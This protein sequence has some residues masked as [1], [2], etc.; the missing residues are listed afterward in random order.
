MRT[1][2]LLRTVLTELIFP[3]SQIR[4]SSTNVAQLYGDH[5][6]L[7]IGS[8]VG[9]RKDGN[10]HQRLNFPYSFL[11]DHCRCPQCYSDATKQRSFDLHSLRPE[12]RPKAVFTDGDQLVIEWNDGHKG[13]FPIDWL[14]ERPKSLRRKCWDKS[15]W[16][17]GIF[18]A[19]TVE[20][21]QTDEG[22]DIH[23][24]NLITYGFSLITGVEP[25]EEA[26]QAVSNRIC[27]PQETIFGTY[28]TFTGGVVDHMD[29][30]YSFEGLGAH[31][32][33]TYYQRTAGYQVTFLLYYSSILR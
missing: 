32:D 16:V 30:A 33:N 11:R 8:S 15:S 9:A 13:H 25:T 17:K 18:P 20:K 26:T 3:P 2:R 22:L 7:N 6:Q 28:W 19:V 21:F 23:L 31:T 12:L 10:D 24:S 5:L 1:S 29:S 4:R 27:R 14:C